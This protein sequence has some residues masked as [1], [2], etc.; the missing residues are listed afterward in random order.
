MLAFWPAK[1]YSPGAFRKTEAI[2]GHFMKLH[3]SPR[4]PFVRKVMIVAQERGLVD[5][6]TCVRTIA[7]TAKPCAA[8]FSQPSGT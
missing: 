4:S 6:L 8:A 5:R 2:A 3:W 1:R 7:A